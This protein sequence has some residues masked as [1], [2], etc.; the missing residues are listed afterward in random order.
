MSKKT[1][2]TVISRIDCMRPSQYAEL[3]YAECAR[4]GANYVCQNENCGY[5]QEWDGKRCETKH[6]EN[7]EKP[8]NGVML[9]TINEEEAEKEVKPKVEK[10][11]CPG[12]RTDVA[13]GHIMVVEIISEKERC[14]QSDDCRFFIRGREFY[15]S[16]YKPKKDLR[17]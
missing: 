16:F 13:T 9:I 2:A 7:K 11:V 8:C 15:C 12:G 17:I 6:C 3:F 14:K 5:T 10:K 4:R 1:V